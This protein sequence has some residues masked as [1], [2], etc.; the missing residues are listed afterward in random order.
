MVRYGPAVLDASEWIDAS[1][2]H[3]CMICDGIEGCGA[4]RDEGFVRCAE[5]P[6]EWPL[7]DR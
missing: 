5:Q 4:M 2:D 3:P 1:P 6:S 7:D